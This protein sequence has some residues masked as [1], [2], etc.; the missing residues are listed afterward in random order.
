MEDLTYAQSVF[1]EGTVVCPKAEPST[2]LVVL[3]IE[4]GVC[5]CAVIGDAARFNIPFFENQL[6]S[7]TEK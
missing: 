1:Q 5:Y 3:K 7:V 2:R 4:N 6:M